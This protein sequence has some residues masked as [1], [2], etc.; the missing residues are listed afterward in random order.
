MACWTHGRSPSPSALERAVRVRRPDASAGPTRSWSCTPPCSGRTSGAARVSSSTR[1]QPT[2]SAARRA[3]SAKAVPGSRTEPMTTCPASQG[4]VWSERRVVNNR[5]SP[6]GSSTAALSS[7]CP[8]ASRPTAPRSP[9]RVWSGVGQNRWC[10]K[11]YVGRSTACASRP[12]RNAVQSISV[13]CTCRCVRAARRVAASER[14]L[15]STGVHTA[16]SGADS[17]AKADRTPSGPSSRNRVTPSA[18]RARIPSA[19]RTAAR[20]WVTQ[21]SGVRSWSGVA[22]WPV[23]FDTTASSGSP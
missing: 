9:V 2:S 18:P 16:S 1:S 22:S 6:S 11:A 12:A 8:V 17:L 19:K 3:S 10:W 21:Y 7:G 15:R 14:S 23:T 4:W 20:T 5:P 13:P